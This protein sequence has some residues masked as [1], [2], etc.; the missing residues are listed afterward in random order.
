MLLNYRYGNPERQLSLP[1]FPAA[2]TSA[3]RNA[4]STISSTPKAERFKGP[5]TSLW[6][7]FPGEKPTLTA[8]L[9]L[10][11]ENPPGDPG[12]PWDLP[13]L[14]THVPKPDPLLPLQLLRHARG[15]SGQGGSF[16]CYHQDL[17]TCTLIT[18][19]K[20][21]THPAPLSPT[22]LH[23]CPFEHPQLFPFTSPCPPLWGLE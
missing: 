20:L 14:S 13:Y 16:A 2:S 3:N 10:G 7:C 5:I 19:N 8:G 4:G 17:P 23:T 6:R 11:L 22:S 15:C 12:A 18:K 21:K 1:R 9:M